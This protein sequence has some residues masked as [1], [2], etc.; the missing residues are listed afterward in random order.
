M[1]NVSPSL[2]VGLG[3]P[4]P[5]YESTRHNVGFAVVDQVLAKLGSRPCETETRPDRASYTVRFRGGR[6]VLMK[7][8][9]FMNESGSAVAKLAQALDL[10]PS[11]IFIV[12]DCI[13]LPLGRIRLKRQGSSGGHRGVESVIQELSADDFPR[14]RV[15]IGRPTAAT[16]DFVLSTWAEPELPLVSQVIDVSAEAVLCVLTNGI[17]AA[18]NRYNGW[19]ADTGSDAVAEEE[20]EQA[21]EDVRNG[22]HS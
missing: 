4:G 19:R 15:G 5:D 2:I 21:I 6:L 14:L 18:M 11:E 12:C 1:S 8:M 3:N 13:D 17:E 22:L 9:T 20:G 7:P 16:V 10:L